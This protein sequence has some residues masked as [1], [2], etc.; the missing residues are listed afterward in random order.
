[1]GHFLDNQVVSTDFGPPSSVG[2]FCRVLNRELPQSV[3]DKFVRGDSVFF[4]NLL[5]LAD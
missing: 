2:S 1:M 5:G 4:P 3:L